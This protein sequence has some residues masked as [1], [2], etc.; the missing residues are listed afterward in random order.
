MI[1]HEC[2]FFSIHQ[3]STFTSSDPL[4]NN[5]FWCASNLTFGMARCDKVEESLAMIAAKLVH[6][7]K[8]AATLKSWYILTKHK[9]DQL[10]SG[11]DGRMV[12]IC[13]T[14][15]LRSCPQLGRRLLG[16]WSCLAWSQWIIIW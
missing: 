16:C 2:H 15:G 12:K 13:F 3:C 9:K 5:P 4:F 6:W 1:R 11:R 8:Y 10:P 14:S 7:K